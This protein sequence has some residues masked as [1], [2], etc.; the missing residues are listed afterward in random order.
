LELEKT[1]AYCWM[2]LR[3]TEAIEPFRQPAY[4]IRRFSLYPLFEQ[5]VNNSAHL[6][7]PFRINRHS[8][9]GGDLFVSLRA[10]Q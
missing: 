10:T 7:F 1:R 9:P 3:D 5:D 2:L 8:S 6:R 4:R